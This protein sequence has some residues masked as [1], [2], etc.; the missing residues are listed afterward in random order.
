MREQKDK[1]KEED[2]KKLEEK[3]SAVKDLLKNASSEKGAIEKAANELSEE[4]QLVGTAMYQQ[5]QP[6]QP[7]PEQPEEKPNGEKK[8][9]K[10]DQAEEGEVVS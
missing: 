2:K 10:K 1:I 3:V 5:N 7:T 8:K 6:E 9:T 4:L